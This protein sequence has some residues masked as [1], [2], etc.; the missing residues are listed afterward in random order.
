[1]FEHKGDGKMKKLRLLTLFFVLNI[2]ISQLIIGRDFIIAGIPEEP[3]RWIESNGKLA[4]IDID[5]IDY[6]MKKMNISYKII[7]ESS[8]TRLEAESQKNNPS[9]D[10]VFTFSKK[11]EREKYLIYPTESHIDFSWNFFIKKGDEGKYK[12]DKLS[13]LKGLRIG[14]TKGFA[15]TE[16][17]WKAGESG[18]LTLDTIVKNEFQMDKLLAGRIDA[19]P[20]NTKTTLYEIKKNGLSREITYLPKPLKSTQYYNTFVKKSNYPN[21]EEIIKKYDVIL[22]EMKRDGTLKNI[23][24]KYGISQY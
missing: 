3:N 24:E 23:L 7:L 11:P 22:K 9:Y 4:G 16:E 17:F 20:L 18:A 21:L 8:S 10:M 5:I 15:Y 6:I 12:F 1:M 2:L 19:V 13:D 14:A